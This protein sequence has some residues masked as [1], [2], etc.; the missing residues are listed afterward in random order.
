MIGWSDFAR[1]RVWPALRCMGITSIDI[2][3][4]TQAP[5]QEFAASGRVFASYDTALAESGATMVYVSTRN[6][7]HAEWARRSLQSGRHTI[8]DKPAALNQT[9]VAS[10][11]DLARERRRLVAEATI[12]PWH[13]QFAEV[14]RVLADRSPATRLTATFTFPTL[15]GGN[16]RHDA[17]MGGGAIFDL[18]PYAV[19]VGRVLFGERPHA[20]AAT[21]VVDAGASVESSFSVLGHY[22]GARTLVGHFGTPGTYTNRLEIAGDAFSLTLP[23]AFTQP[24][25]QSTVIELYEGR[26]TTRLETAAADSMAMFLSDVMDHADRGE[27]ASFADAMLL[28]AAALSAL[29]AAAR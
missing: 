19:S 18:G 1:R 13:P 8:I 9:D 4:L 20:I 24:T 25:D 2:A 12:Y 29:R 22:S 15:P 28:D 7:D 27:F 26:Q 5:G 17:A 14:R 16:F 11:V 10:L 6:V 21:A 23:R 3:S